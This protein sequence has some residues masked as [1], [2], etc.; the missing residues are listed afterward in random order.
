M[1]NIFRIHR[2]VE[3]G[4]YRLVELFW[5]IRTYGILPAIFAD[6][7]E[8]DG[9]MAHTK[10]FV[11]D[12]RSEMF[13][14]NDDGS[15]TIGLTHLREASDEFLY[16]DIIHELCHV[17]QHLQ[18]RNLYDRSKAYVDRETEIEAYQVTV[19]EARRIGLKDEAIANYLRVSW[20]TPEEHKRLVRRLDVTEKYDL[21]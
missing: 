1:K 10:V 17:K 21:T 8:I 19:Q 15:I 9:V 3:P 20:I 12:R 6:A 5:D 7:E 14:D 18:G 11:V 16:L 13:V 2:R 4:Q